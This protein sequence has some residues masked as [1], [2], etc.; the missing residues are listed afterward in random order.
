MKILIL[1]FLLVSVFL[2]ACTPEEKVNKEEINSVSQQVDSIDV[3]TINGLD[4]EIDL[5]EFENLDENL[6][7]EDL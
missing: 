6:D 5:N 1:A 2:I 7:L 4:D 3:E